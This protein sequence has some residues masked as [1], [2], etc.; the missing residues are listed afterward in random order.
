MVNL[1]LRRK[2]SK[3]KLLALHKWSKFSI[4]CR[5]LNNILNRFSKSNKTTAINRWKETI[6]K[7]LRM[8]SNDYRALQTEVEK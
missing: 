5:R 8:Y 4:K 6:Y 7:E 1:I 2:S 3:I